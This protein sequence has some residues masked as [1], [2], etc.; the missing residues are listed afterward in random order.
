MNEKRTEAGLQPLTIDNTLV[1]VARYKSVDMVQNNFF[2]HINPDGTRWTNWLHTIGYDYTS[3][4]EN[5][6]C[7][8]SDTVELFNK[9][10]N[11]PGHRANMMNDKYTKVG[12]GVINGNSKYIGTQEL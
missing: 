8:N 11:S 4:G 5:I 10:W 7:N 1:Q 2:N 6:A 9:W 3:A 12:I